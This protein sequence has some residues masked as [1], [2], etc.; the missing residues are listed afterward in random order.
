MCRQLAA[1]LEVGGDRF[2][3]EAEALRAPIPIVRIAASQITGNQNLRGCGP[4]A[5][6]GA[7]SKRS[8]A[9]WR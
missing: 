5:A 8:R 1:D 9:A 7:G 4:P 2:L 6:P 3:K